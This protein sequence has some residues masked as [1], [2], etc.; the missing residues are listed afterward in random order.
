[1]LTNV[2]L[3]LHGTL[4]VFQTHVCFESAAHTVMCTI[5]LTDVSAVEKANGLFGTVPTR[6]QLVHG[7]KPA[8]QTVTFISLT[9]R[10]KL[11]IAIRDAWVGLSSTQPSGDRGE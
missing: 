9:Q 2:K 4:F 6:V 10:E 5:P 11:F 3:P 7:V 1:M 8:Q